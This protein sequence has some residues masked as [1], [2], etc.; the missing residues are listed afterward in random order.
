MTPA[1]CWTRWEIEAI[2]GA[3]GAGGEGPHLSTEGSYAENHAHDRQQ[4]DPEQ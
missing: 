4:A 2:F 3:L 1:S